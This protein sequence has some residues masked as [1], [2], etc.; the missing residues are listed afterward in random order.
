[1]KHK[2]EK[3]PDKK[4]HGTGWFK[5]WI[6]KVCGCRKELHNSRFA[7][8]NYIRSRMIYDHYIECIDEDFEKTKTID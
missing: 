3:Q 2:W 5:I 6:C 1:M 4:I 7:E 8:P